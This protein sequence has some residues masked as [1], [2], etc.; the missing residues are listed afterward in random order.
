MRVTDS[1]GQ[2]YTIEPETNLSEANLNSANLTW[3]NLTDA[4]ML[5]KASFTN[6]KYDQKTIFPPH[7]TPPPSR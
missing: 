7:F 5:N 2:Q 4:T 3:A 6:I 1:D